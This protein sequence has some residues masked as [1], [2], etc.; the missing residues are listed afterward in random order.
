LEEADVFDEDDLEDPDLEKL[1]EGAVLGGWLG[2]G[3]PR[4]EV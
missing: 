1:V 4:E 2:I 3:G